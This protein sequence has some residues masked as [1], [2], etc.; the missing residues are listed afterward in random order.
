M[1]DLSAFTSKVTRGLSNKDENSLMAEFMRIRR[2]L[3]DHQKI[4][5]KCSEKMGGMAK[6]DTSGLSMF[7]NDTDLKISLLKKQSV[8][9]VYEIARIYGFKRVDLHHLTLQEAQEVVITILDQVMRRLTV[10][11]QKRFSLEIITGKGLHSQG[12]AVLH[13]RI[14][15]FLE[16]Q[17]YQAKS[18]QDQGRL[19]VI[20]KA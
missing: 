7:R 13:P 3:R 9:V 17:G 12:E 19:D 2:E 5:Q 11:N 8:F 1:G 6:K 4:Y 16:E 10:D 20:I 14:K 18:S 15:Q